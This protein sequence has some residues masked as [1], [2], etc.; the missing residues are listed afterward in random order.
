MYNITVEVPKKLLES[1]SS[2]DIRQRPY[3]LCLECP[4][5]SKTCD[6]PNILAMENERWIEWAHSRMTQLKITRAKL[7]EL[8]GV[9]EGTIVSIM[10]GRTKDARFS[11]VRDMT[12]ALSGGCWGEYPCHFASLMI[13]SELKEEDTD[14]D[15]MKLDFSLAQRKI[16]TYEAELAALRRAVDTAEEKSDKRIAEVKEEARKKVDYLRAQVEKL[17]ARVEGKEK[18]I[19]ILSYALAGAGLLIISILIADILMPGIGF[20]R[21]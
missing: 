5:F 17:D 10:S 18:T 15:R 6:G 7:A 3:D 9:P 8:S 11:T 20:I 2:P 13:N 12:K 4:Y 16:D 14:I 19:K 1:A 21:Y